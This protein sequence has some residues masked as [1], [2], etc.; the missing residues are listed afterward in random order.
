MIAVLFGTRPEFIKLAPILKELQLEKIPFILIHSGQHYSPELDIEIIRDLNLPRPN[1]N[2]KVGSESHA[3]QTGKIMVGVEEIL[4]KVKPKILVVHGDTNT[5]LAGSLAAKKLHIAVAHVEAGLRSFDNGMPE[6]I[7]RIITDKISDLL[8]T[9]TK[10]TK[11]NL[12][13]DGIDENRIFISGNTI[14]DAIL[15]SL[16]LT[17]TSPILKH[18]GLKENNYVLVTAHRVANVD[19]ASRLKELVS[20]LNFTSKLLG[21][22][23]IWPMHPHTRKQLLKNKIK[24]NSDLQI[25]DPTNYKDML[26]LIKFAFLILTDSGGIQEEAYILKKW[27]ITLRNTTERPETLTANF[28]VDLDKNKL[29]KAILAFQNKQVF[30]KENIYGVGNASKLIVKHLKNYLYEKI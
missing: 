20:L 13:E 2:L 9:P 29:K 6:E 18:L 10:T 12:L 25:L 14:V 5:M 23:I 15:S 7:N 8:F 30:W 1:Y 17:K 22:K 21:K 27:L 3:K 16:P 28:L 19:K 11:K 26:S 24:L 4:E